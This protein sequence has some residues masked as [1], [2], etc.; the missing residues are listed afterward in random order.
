MKENIGK[1]WKSCGGLAVPGFSA[2]RRVGIIAQ[3]ALDKWL[4]YRHRGGETGAP[5]LASVRL[6]SCRLPRRRGLEAPSLDYPLKP[7]P[8]FDMFT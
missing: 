2:S 7:P 3:V 4:H 1:R 8:I 6:G 5:S